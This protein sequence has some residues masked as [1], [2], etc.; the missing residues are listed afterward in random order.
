MAT[1]SQ[2]IDLL[3]GTGAVAKLLGIK[4]SSVSFWRVGGIRRERVAELVVATGRHADSLDDLQPHRWHMVW[5]ELEMV[6]SSPSIP[7]EQAAC[8]DRTKAL[9]AGPTQEAA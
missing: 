3:G 1:A 5:P 6:R 8:S 4:S 2:L 7:T 9:P